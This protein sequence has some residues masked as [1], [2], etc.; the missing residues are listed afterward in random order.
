MK[1]YLSTLLL[2]LLS[3]RTSAHTITVQQWNIW[4]VD[5]GYDA[6]VDE[7]VRLRPDFVTLSEVRNYHGTRFCDR[8]TESLRQRGE[9]YWSFH[10]Y[11]TGLLSRHPFTSSITVVPCANDHGSIHGLRA[12]VGHHFAPSAGIG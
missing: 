4:Q 9:E 12:L 7:I 10:S 11:N 5:G 2:A 8:I 6:I 1:H 3:L